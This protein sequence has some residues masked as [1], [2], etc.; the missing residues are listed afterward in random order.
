MLTA[1]RGRNDFEVAIVCALPLEFDAVA[2]LLDQTWNEKGDRYGRASGDR[3]R[4]VTGRMGDTNVVVLLL[5]KVG[6]AS[7]ARATEGLRFSFPKVRLVLLTGTCGGA[8]TTADGDEVLLGD[9]IIS[10]SIVQHDFGR[11]CPNGFATK[12]A[13][14]DLLGPL[15]RDLL[16]LVVHLETFM[17]RSQLEARTHSAL[18]ALQKAALAQQKASTYDYPGAHQDRLF[19]A[20]YVHKHDH[21]TSVGCDN[22]FEIGRERTEA[23]RQLEREGRDWEAQAPRLHVGRFGSGDMVVS[24]GKARDR[25]IEQHNISGFEMEGAGVWGEL[26]CLVI[27]GVCNYA[28][29]HT[30]K[31]WRGFAAATAA[32]VTKAFLAEYAKTNAP[33]PVILD[34]VEPCWNMESASGAFAMHGGDVHFSDANYPN[35]RL[36]RRPAHAESHAV[37]YRLDAEAVGSR[38]LADEMNTPAPLVDENQ[39]ATSWD[40]EDWA[41]VESHPSFPQGNASL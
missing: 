7:A 4:Y 30:N 36:P 10:K 18:L 22:A 27:K 17:G 19:A 16:S 34:D 11:S 14:E 29:S 2:L 32:S 12:D 39:R 6:K 26:P 1:P 33:A 25:L 8:P 24:C 41:R 3:N 40:L 35:Y 13:I 23:K 5:P 37:Q 31:A 9:V 28:D 20:D 15:P 21:T 38:D